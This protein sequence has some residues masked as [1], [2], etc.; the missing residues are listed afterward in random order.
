MIGVDQR[1]LLTD[2]LTPPAGFEF[3]AGVAVTYSLDLVT[4]LGVPLHLAWLASAQ[5]QAEPVLDPLPVVEAMRRV[6]GKLTVFCQQARI[7]TPRAASPLLG[8]VEP[9][10][11]EVTSRHG[12]AFHPKVWLLKFLQPDTGEVRLTLLV[13]S[14]NLTDDRS[15]DISLRLDGS[16]GRQVQGENRPI[17]DLFRHAGVRSRK[18]LSTSRQQQ[19]ESLLEEVMRC[20]WSL[21]GAFESIRFH[22]IGTAAKRRPWLPQPDGGRWDELGLVSPFVTAGALEALSGLARAPLFAIS[23]AEELQKIQSM[24]PASFEYRVLNEQAAAGDDEDDVPGRQR[25]LHG[26]AYVGKRGWNTHLFVGSANATSAALLEGTNTEFM[27]E[28]VGRASKVGRPGDWLADK[29]L[30]PLLTVFE[31]SEDAPAANQNEQ[32]LENVRQRIAGAGLS[33]RCQ[34]QQD[35]WQLSLGSFADVDFS[36]AAVSV[37]PVSLPQQ[38]QAPVPPHT[39]D[40]AL[41]GLAPQEITSLFAFRLAL[42]DAELAFALDLPIDGAPPDRDLEILRSVLKNRQAFIRYLLLLLGDWQPLGGGE[43][44]RR[45]IQATPGSSAADEAPV[46]ELLARAL[47]REPIRLQHVQEVVDRI[48]RGETEGDPV[49]PP[50]FVQLWGSFE[51]VLREQ[52]Q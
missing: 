16:I 8:L 37:W 11:H 19:I 26:K 10:V 38:R 17:R 7:H 3:A 42:G 20:A 45:W 30:G 18:A 23:R 24:L 9:M 13:L 50:E 34:H 12:G 33:I 4:L 46:F 32:V 51:T 48:R 2:A 52:A 14:R 22:L 49:L 5:S 29:G 35:G 41:S 39:K 40:V 27:A 15:W 25:G 28:L 43:G 1:S 47:A 31:A 21:P 36:G 6:S 44:L